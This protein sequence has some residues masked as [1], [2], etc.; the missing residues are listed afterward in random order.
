ME[1]RG[2][3]RVV[4]AEGRGSRSSA[5]TARRLDLEPVADDAGVGH[6]TVAVGVAERR[7]RGDVKAVQAG[8]LGPV[9][10]ACGCADTRMTAAL[11]RH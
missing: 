3:P 11:R 4:R 9:V 5:K 7:D 1:N 10:L 6:E 8:P 2:T